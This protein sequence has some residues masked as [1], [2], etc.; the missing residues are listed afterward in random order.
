M[1]RYRWVA[2]ATSVSIK[3]TISEIFLNVLEMCEVFSHIGL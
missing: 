2:M 3:L 1:R